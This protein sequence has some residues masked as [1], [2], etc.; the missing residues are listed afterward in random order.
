MV[1]K[2]VLLSLLIS[3][4]E[5][6]EGRYLD[7]PEVKSVSLVEPEGLYVQWSPVTQRQDDPVIGYKI[8][9]WEIP[10]SSD[11]EIQLINANKFPGVIR[12]EKVQQ[13]FSMNNSNP[14]TREVIINSQ[15][16][17]L[18][19]VTVDKIKYN[20]IYEV[21]VLGFKRDVDGPLSVPVRIKIVKGS[22]YQVVLQRTMSGCQ[23]TVPA[24]VEYSG[25]PYPYQYNSF[26]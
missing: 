20:T 16:S 25:D 7:A 26:F 12:D 13:T 23:V 18:Y 17:K 10:E 14:A 22:G 4:S 15:E 11:T 1:R 3:I 2:F 21:R 19:M 5:G 6:R 9:I 24:E 8:R